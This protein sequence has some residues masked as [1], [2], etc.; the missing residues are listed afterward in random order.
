MPLHLVVAR[1][2]RAPM[3]MGDT[4][5]LTEEDQAVLIDP[6]SMTGEAALVCALPTGGWAIG[7]RTGAKCT[8]WIA[9]EAFANELDPPHALLTEPGLFT[10][11]GGGSQPASLD[12]AALLPHLEPYGGLGRAAKLVAGIVRTLREGGRPV[13]V[14]TAA[15]QVSREA[16]ALL[17]VAV[18]GRGTSLSVGHP[19]PDPRRFQ[20]AV[21]DA[22]V[23]GYAMLYAASPPDEGEDLVAWFARDRLREDPQALCVPGGVTE[24][25]VR[26]LL[27]EGALGA[28]AGREGAIRGM[29]A[30][31]RAGAPVDEALLDEL[32]A[33]TVVTPDH[34]PWVEVGKRPSVVRQAA[35]EALV[36]Q[37]H[38]LKPTAELLATVG[39]MYPRGAPLAPWCGALMEWLRKAR[40]PQ[41]FV[42]QI[43]EAL[44]EWP[45]SAARANRV[46]L[47]TE[48]VR[49]LVDREHFRDAVAAVSGPVA[50]AML[51]EGSGSAVATMWGT[52]PEDRRNPRRL[53]A[54]V[55]RL[56]KDPRGDRA[57]AQLLRHVRTSAAEVD[58]LL[59]TWV[60]VRGTAAVD[61]GDALYRSVVG[62]EHAGAWLKAALSVHPP[63]LVVPLVAKAAT[64][65]EDPLW[66]EAEGAAGEALS[67]RE[68]FA[69]LRLFSSGRVALEPLARGL[70]DGALRE[71]RFPDASVGEAARAFAEVPGSAPI[72]GLVAV[73]A[74]SPGRWPD[75][76]VDATVVALCE[77]PPTNGVER[78]VCLHAAEALGAAAE[79]EPLDHARWIVRFALAPDGDATG[80]AETLVTSLVV[81]LTS[82]FDAGPH[83][84]RVVI[85]MLELPSDHPAL[86]GLLGDWLPDA[87]QGRVPV[88]FVEAVQARGVPQPLA[89][90]WQRLIS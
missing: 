53:Q 16:L 36:K 12:V 76:V 21:V 10:P 20:L 1:C 70:I 5:V 37:A 28:A 61:E 56:V 81:G 8:W 32:V 29:V 72:W 57:A 46:S 41:P 31:L 35:V 82:R 6:V 4:E 13:A 83:L 51:E 18:L 73:T 45:Q 22:D 54:L 77:T 3:L 25:H 62:T 66:I 33:M 30:R 47:W 88:T 50:K 86:T 67:A 48:V 19:E 52:L 11:E 17:V 7:R 71:T 38:V 90:A 42:E 39:R 87:W 59:K 84:A 60:R 89:D 75:E 79:W 23:E 68:R 65:P 78:Q 85:E 64:G 74:A 63:A 24:V 49:I 43:E 80:F 26:D 58:V 69:N 55:E 40:R 44:L 34:R 9:D 27:R 2:G 15:P 14:V